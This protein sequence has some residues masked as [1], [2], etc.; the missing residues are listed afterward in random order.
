[1]QGL[2]CRRATRHCSQ[3]LLQLCLL[4]LHHGQL[5]LEGGLALLQRGSNGGLGHCLGLLRRSWG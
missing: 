2:C 5:L 3:L 4:G 1:L